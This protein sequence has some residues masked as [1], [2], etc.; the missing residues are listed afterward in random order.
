MC[1]T[2]FKQIRFFR[3][4]VLAG[5]FTLLAVL[6]PTVFAD[7]FILDWSQIGFVDGT[8]SLQT[9]PNVSNSGVEMTTEFRILDSAFQDVGIYI[10]GTSP[11]NLGMPKPDGTALAVRDINERSYPGTDIGY[12]MTIITF[13]PNVTIKDLWTEPF[14]NWTTQGIRK[15]M[16]LQA[17]DVNGN[18]LSPIAW[19]T[20]G[21]SN[22]LVEPHPDNG[23]PWLRS[24]YPDTQNAYSGS[25]D[26]NYGDQLISELHWYSWGLASN[27]NLSHLVG[28]SL[29]G[30]FEFL[31]P[32]PTVINLVSAGV[33]GNESDM[34]V[35]ILLAFL[36][37]TLTTLIIFQQRQHKKT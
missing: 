14:Y 29:L 18:G 37:I 17:F 24:S 19:Q 25:F 27:G 11:L 3:L 28:S 22:L 1:L 13:S 33:A 26:I 21:G 2:H 10:P 32:P 34:V 23:E 31:P 6:V 16:A 4:S 30:D 35:V 7:D 36:L 8:S 15:H 5:L 20:Y 9:F 12:V